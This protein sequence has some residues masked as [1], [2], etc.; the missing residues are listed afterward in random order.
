MFTTPWCSN[1]SHYNF[2]HPD[3][4]DFTEIHSSLEAL[5][6]G[7]PVDIPQY[8]FVTSAR[9]PQSTHVP[10]ADVILFDGI[11]AFHQPEVRGLF[12]LKIFVDTD[13][14]TRLAR[15]VRRD[16]V[17]RGRDIIQVLDQY[18]ETV[19]PS[20]DSFILPTKKHADII[21]PRG[22]ENL[23]AIDLIHHHIRMKLLTR[24]PSAAAA[25]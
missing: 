1:I 20:F 22:A 17:E 5:K 23:P 24:R 21:V 10:F 6:R 7:A 19:K 3:A 16:I 9:L 13:A 25:L 15:R 12:D 14:D 8:D 2:D 18:E 11:M 4:F